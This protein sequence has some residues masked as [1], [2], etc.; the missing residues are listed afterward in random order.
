V[1]SEE[2]TYWHIETARRVLEQA[3]DA[4]DNRVA[5][6]SIAHHVHM[7]DR[8]RLVREHMEGLEFEYDRFWQEHLDPK[9][10]CS[11]S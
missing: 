9:R 1:N 5:E 2:A 3:K 10:N 4:M 8:I 6:T 7:M 11:L